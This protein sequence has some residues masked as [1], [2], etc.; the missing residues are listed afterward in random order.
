MVLQ[1]ARLTGWKGQS[2]VIETA[3]RLIK[4]FPKL[5]FVLAGDA[6]GREDYLAGLKQKINAGGITKCGDIARPLPGSCS[7]YGDC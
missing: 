2:V 4:E 7:R 5:R 3:E 1:L 6:Q